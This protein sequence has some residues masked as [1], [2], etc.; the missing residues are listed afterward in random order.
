MGSYAPL[1]KFLG[2]QL[3]KTSCMKIT[4]A[5]WNK[6]NGWKTIVNS[7]SLKNAQLVLCFGERAILEKKDIT[8]SLC[9]KYKNAQIIFCSS[10]GEIADVEVSSQSLSVTAIEFE[11][12]DIAVISKN[13]SDFDD[14]CSIGKA[15]VEELQ[16]DD[17]RHIF[18]LSDGQK[19][20][21][22]ELVLGMTAAKTSDCK[23]TGGLAGDGYDFQKTCVGLN[24][25]STE[26]EIVAIGFYGNHI[27]VGFGS[28]GGWDTFGPERIVTKSESNVLYELDGK[29]A[30][31]L[32]KEYLGS[33]ANELPG[34]ALYYPLSIRSN[35]GD[36]NVVRTILSIDEETQSMTFAG[37]IPE[38]CIAKL[39]KHNP[40]RLID[41]AEYAAQESIRKYDKNK[42]PDL[43]L[44]VSCVGRRIVLGHN[45]DEEIE[46]VKDIYSKDTVVTGFYSYGEICPQSYLS[47]CELH[48]QTM[49]ITTLSEI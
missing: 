14:S 28:K 27:E 2:K 24:T 45:I 26:G 30:L 39:M 31:G 43:A 8:H 15:L 36:T 44:L 18:V 19:V 33:A 6:Q 40:D 49:T 29:S 34:A 1:T 17:L 23:I 4:Q 41:G 10:A 25:C 9:S 12:T 38:G 42:A 13:I 21:G 5:T 22:S 3:Y 46:V 37:D 20:N 32:Y 7:S 47:N 48:N 16:K 11:K 35:D